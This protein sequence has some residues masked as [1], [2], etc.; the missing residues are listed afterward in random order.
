MNWPC[1][2]LCR[3]DCCRP[4]NSACSVI[5]N[6]SRSLHNV[7]IMRPCSRWP[8][9]GSA[10]DSVSHRFELASSRYVSRQRECAEVECQTRTLDSEQIAA[11][12]GGA[13]Q[14]SAAPA[15]CRRPCVA[16]G[17]PPS[18]HAAT[19]HQAGCSRPHTGHG[20]AI[21]TH[22]GKTVRDAATLKPG[23]ELLTRFQTGQAKSVVE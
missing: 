12:T 4:C 17:T 7:P 9:A 21:T 23:D 15:Q 6:G 16:S 11:T 2:K 13:R 22:N 8:G 5:V 1:S 10:F 14:I 3:T 18:R 19:Q 20:I